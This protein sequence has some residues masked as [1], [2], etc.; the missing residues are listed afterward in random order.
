MDLFGF[1]MQSSQRW[2]GWRH[3]RP[4]RGQAERLVVALRPSH[5]WRIYFVWWD[6]D[7]WDVGLDDHHG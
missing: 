5:H 4:A 7:A 1:M 3:G 2:R 6:G